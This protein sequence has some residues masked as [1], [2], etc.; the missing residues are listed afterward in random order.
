MTTAPIISLD[1]Y[2]QAL[3]K[4]LPR[5][6]VWNK[7]LSSNMAQVMA[8]LAPSFKRLNDRA[9]NVI[10]D[11]FVG[12]T[13]ELLPE[14]E[15]TLG[16][17]DPCQGPN[18]TAANRRKQAVAR[19]VG[20]GGL[21][22][23]AITAFAQNL[24][25]PIQIREYAPFFADR[26]TADSAVWDE[27]AAY[28][29]TVIAPQQIITYFSAD[30]SVAGDPLVSYQSTVLQCELARVAP[31]HTQVG[32][33]FTLPTTTLSTPLRIGF[34]AFTALGVFADSAGLARIAF[35][36]LSTHSGTLSSPVALAGLA[37]LSFLPNIQFAGVNVVSS[38]AP[39]GVFNAVALFNSQ[40][41][42][43]YR[44]T[45]L[46]PFSSASFWNLPIGSSALW[47]LASDPDTVALRAQPAAIAAANGGAAIYVGQASD[48]LVLF[49]STS[50]NQRDAG[51]QALVHVPIGAAPGSDGTMTLFDTTQPTEVWTFTNCQIQ[52]QTGGYLSAISA[53]C[54]VT[55]TNGE[56][57]VLCGDGTDTSTLNYGYGTAGTIRQWE[58]AAG[59]VSHTLRFAM[60]A[61]A[62]SRPATLPFG[63]THVFGSTATSGRISYGC[64]I[65]IPASVNLAS[66]G[67]SAGG[68]IIAQTLQNHGAV[69]RLTS[70]VKGVT[71]FAEPAL[72]NDALI[73]EARSDLAN[74]LPQYLS[75]LR[76]QSASSING[77]GAPIVAA[78]AALNPNVCGTGGTQLPTVPSGLVGV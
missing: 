25:Y 29:W 5:G 64:T 36:P 76:N 4:L 45:W 71:L 47:S 51:L 62:V 50:S 2:Q 70:A 19:F 24:G 10:S 22:I 12:T 39:F 32:F 59:V 13:N 30:L 74:I 18:A 17:P 8:A 78:A 6:R 7:D 43:P 3:L 67:L 65:G 68:L 75:I 63:V 48:P 34:G 9:I 66:L 73:Q 1:D 60:P 53:A 44:Q 27:S 15:E 61:S 14:W 40:T 55:A 69:M 56:A 46:Q 16:L 41:P 42:A 58:W 20:T 33:A 57:D 23:P 11:A 49:T 35:P 54:S 37:A 52:N 28:L 38:V 21:S 72:E 31:A 77:G 26:G